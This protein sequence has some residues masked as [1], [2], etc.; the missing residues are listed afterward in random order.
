MNRPPTRSCS[1][2]RSCLTRTLRTP[3]RVVLRRQQPIHH[4]LRQQAGLL[5][6]VCRLRPAQRHRPGTT[7]VTPSI[8]TSR[9]LGCVRAWVEVAC[10]QEV[11][12]PLLSGPGGNGL[13]PADSR[14]C[15]RTRAFAR[16]QLTVLLINA[17]PTR[18]WHDLSVPQPR[19]G[20]KLCVARCLSF[21][22]GLFAKYLI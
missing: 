15:A 2:A 4:R 16:V 10:Q 21:S 9:S 20:F 5:R 17:L 6:R 8:N 22:A 18:N 13:P 14:W 12:S 7:G 11:E 19:P 1:S 3:R